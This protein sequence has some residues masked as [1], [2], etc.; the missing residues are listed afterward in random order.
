MNDWENASAIL[1]LSLSSLLSLFKKA[2]KTRMQGMKGMKT[3][4]QS[5]CF[6][7]HVFA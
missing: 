1:L 4:A 5:R 7:M 3:A 6:S 2:F